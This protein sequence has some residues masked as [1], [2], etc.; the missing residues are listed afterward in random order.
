MVFQCSKSFLIKCVIV[1]FTNGSKQTNNTY[2][3]RN[4]N[5]SVQRILATLGFVARTRFEY[6]S[7]FF[8][9][10]LTLSFRTQTKYVLFYVCVVIAVEYNMWTVNTWQWITHTHK[11]DRESKILDTFVSFLWYIYCVLFTCL[12]FF[13]LFFS[14]FCLFV[15]LSIPNSYRR[16]GY[17]LAVEPKHWTCIVTKN[18]KWS[19]RKF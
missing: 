18:R 4:R 9:L 14:F 15:C 19:R 2:W 11:V 16:C 13:S 8:S 5:R 10:S 6:T 17:S 7:N 3:P 12:S 1:P